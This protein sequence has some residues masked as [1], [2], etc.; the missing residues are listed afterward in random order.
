[1]PK[2][3]FLHVF[4]PADAFVEVA[5]CSVLAAYHKGVGL[6]GG[7]HENLGYLHVFGG[8]GRKQDDVGNVIARQWLDAVVHVVGFLL[9]A[10]EA[11]HAEMGFH[12]PGLDVRH[13]HGRMG[14]VDAQSVRQG[15]DCR[16][17]GTVHAAAPVGSLAGQAAQVDDMAVVAADHA[18]YDEPRHGEQP[19]D[20]GIDHGVPFI[21]AALV[22]LVQP[23]CQAGIVDEDIGPAPAVLQT[24]YG[25]CGGLAVANVK[26]QG[27]DLCPQ[28]PDLFHDGLKLLLRAACQ[29]EIVA[30]LGEFPGAGFANA[31]CRACNECYFL[32]HG[33]L[34]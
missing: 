19:L 32:I 6:V 13:P 25:N 21:Q 7:G 20:V 10:A 8:V 27:L 29:D 24:L 3:D 16:L 18:R 1:M 2:A 23:Q 11:G 17:G 22:F 4:L 31:A 5:S 28:L 12:Q 30:V 34:F 33:V 9:V 14:H 15:L 26:D